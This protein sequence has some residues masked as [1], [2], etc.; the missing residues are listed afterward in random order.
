[1]FGHLK[2]KPE[3]KMV[4]DCRHP[5]V[6]ESVFKHEVN[7]KPFCGE[8]E[9]ESPRNMPTPRG[10]GMSIHCFVDSDHAG[11]VVTRRS[12]TGIMTFLN[13]SPVVWH[14]ERQNTVETSAFGSE[15]VAV[16]IA[17]E[18]IVFFMLYFPNFNY[19]LSLTSLP[20]Y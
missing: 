3:V 18:M 9:E 15:F 20:V 2:T 16:K 12:H 8:V 7:W 10:C 1:M 13:K 14:S 11:N 19:Y 6:D 4:H 5:D 17:E